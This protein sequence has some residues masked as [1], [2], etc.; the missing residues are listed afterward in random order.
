MSESGQVASE[1]ASGSARLSLRG[2]SLRGRRLLARDTHLSEK[3]SRSFA[4]K[5]LTDFVGAHIAPE[6]MP[7]SKRE[8]YNAAETLMAHSVEYCEDLYVVETADIKFDFEQHGDRIRATTEMHSTV[9]IECSKQT[10]LERGGVQ[11]K[12]RP[13]YK[14]TWPTS[15]RLPT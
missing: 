3:H 6:A 9:G 5:L 11:A 2:L 14:N 7:V 15:R 8:L 4:E 1:P 10:F 12:R 13:S